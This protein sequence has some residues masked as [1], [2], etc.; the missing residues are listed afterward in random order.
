VL[1]LGLF[2]DNVCVSE[3]LTLDSVLIVCKIMSVDSDIVYV[4]PLMLFC[5]FSVTVI[6]LVTVTRKTVVRYKKQIRNVADI[7]IPEF[8]VQS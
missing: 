6:G 3:I 2:E 1:K 8:T 7:F 4:F 5:C